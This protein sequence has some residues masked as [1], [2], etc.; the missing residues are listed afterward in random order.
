MT[1][2]AS[3]PFLGTTLSKQNAPTSTK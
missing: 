1:Q 3:V 2:P